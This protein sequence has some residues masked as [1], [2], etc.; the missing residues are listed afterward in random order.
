MALGFF[1]AYVASYGVASTVKMISNVCYLNK[2]KKQI[3]IKISQSL[4]E[5]NHN[6]INYQN[7]DSSK[8]FYMRDCS[9]K[10]VQNIQVESSRKKDGIGY[11][12]RQNSLSH[13]GQ[14]REN[15]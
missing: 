3:K 6:S 10:Q 4:L 12:D 14:M 2:Q 8:M 11:R 1:V 7:N 13:Q 9:R 5:A 15:D